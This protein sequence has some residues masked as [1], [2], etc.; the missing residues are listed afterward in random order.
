M[1]ITPITPSFTGAS[2]SYRINPKNVT[3]KANN[4]LTYKVLE[5]VREHNV[6][7]KFDNN[8]MNINIEDITFQKETAANVRKALKSQNIKYRKIING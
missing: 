2:V 6:P 1:F 5:I 8:F 7:A 3:N 4:L